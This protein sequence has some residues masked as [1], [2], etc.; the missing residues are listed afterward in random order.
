[1]PVILV[2][3]KM[4]QGKTNMVMKKW[5]NEDVKAWVTV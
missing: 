5:V 3:G 1:M 2:T 4:G